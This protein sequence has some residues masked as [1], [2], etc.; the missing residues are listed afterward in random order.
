[1]ALAVAPGIAPPVVAAV[2]EVPPDVPPLGPGNVGAV[3]APEAP[4]LGEVAVLGSPVEA[5]PPL[6]EFEQAAVEA[7]NPRRT[8]DRVI[9]S[10]GAG[11]AS[12][13]SRRGKLPWPTTGAL[14]SGTNGRIQRTGFSLS[15]T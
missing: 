1:V 5:A 6:G 13:L 11:D 7:N 3:L 2:A 9:V 10:R 12:I 14:E 15:A 4:M 8:I